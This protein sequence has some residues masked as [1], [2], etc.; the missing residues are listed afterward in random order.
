MSKDTIYA[1]SSASGQAGVAVIR[2]SGDKVKD[3][4]NILTGKDNIK[5]RYV[6]CNYIYDENKNVIDQVVL[7]YFQSPNSFTGEDV[8]EIQCHGSRAV[9]QKILKTLSCIDGCRMAERGEFTRRAVYNQKMDLTSAEGLLDLI[10]SDTEAQRQWAIR[11][12]G[13]ELQKIYDGWRDVLVHQL[14]YL[15]AFI[16]FPE[17]EIPSSRMNEINN[18]I[19]ELIEK[20]QKHLSA[21]EKGQMLKDGFKIAI[22]GAPNVGKSSIINKLSKKDVAITSEIAGTTRDVVEVWLDVSG[23][24]VVIADTAGI[25]E[26]DEL[27]EKEGIKRALQRAEDADLVIAV[28]DA[29]KYPVF[30]EK[31]EEVCQKA[32][33]VIRVFNKKD[34]IDKD[35]ADLCVS[36]HTDENIDVLWNEISLVVENEMGKSDDPML[37][38]LRYKECLEDCL[39]NLK[40]FYMVDELELKT[41]DIRLASRA[42]GKITGRVEIDEI[43]DII[44]SSV[45]IGK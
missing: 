30:D 2:V 4:F 18:Q 43:F 20:I 38:R 15:E 8:L 42:L 9:I 44:F 6:Q 10:Q 13:G 11:Q 22:I 27:I 14:A 45:C 36:A 28:G 31:I 3:V 23:Y 5:N 24:P 19:N 35:I 1:L 32:K 12:M 25:H 29:T 34:L 41:E 7:I 21:G 26:S 16:D 37:T 17:E 40:H 39:N 33:K